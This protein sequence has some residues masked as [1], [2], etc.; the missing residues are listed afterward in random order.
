M[1]GYVVKEAN[2]V[3]AVVQAV[4]SFISPTVVRNMRTA[5]EVHGELVEVAR[6]PQVFEGG[7][8]REKPTRPRR[9]RR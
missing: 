5:E 3:W 8:Q 6:R 4:G 9:K 1:A 7:A 2:D